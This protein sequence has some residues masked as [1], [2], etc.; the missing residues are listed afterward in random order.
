MP[1]FHPL[2]GFL[3]MSGKGIS[4]NPRSGYVDRPMQVPCG[5]C[6][7]CRLERSRQWAARC[8]HEASLHPFNCFLTLTYDDDHMPPGQTL[9]KKHMQD[10]FK[11]L[12]KSI[13]PH[14]ISH[15]YCGEYGDQ[16]KRPHYH[17]LLFGYDFP[18]KRIYKKAAQGYLF[19]SDTLDSL[20]SFGLCSIGS[21][22]FESA[23]YV[24]RYSLKKINGEPAAQHYQGRVPEFLGMST[25]PAIGLR[26]I[27]KWHADTYPSD[28]VVTRGHETKPPAYYDKVLKRND[29]G[30]YASIKRERELEALKPEN[31][32]HTTPARL[33]A[34]EEVTKAKTSIYSRNVT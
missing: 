12:R 3:H 31:N 18:D 27:Q 25:R 5:K 34:R 4:F 7:G 9:V 32:L 22:T 20:W 29:P 1:C 28:T 30:L 11:R 26:W 21:L 19:R 33:A 23:A 6:I 13:H 17:A 14:K 16:T 8:M 15:F 24:A 10:F 2:N